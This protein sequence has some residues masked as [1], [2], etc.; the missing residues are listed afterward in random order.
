MFI[1]VQY[2]KYITALYFSSYLTENKTIRAL[3]SIYRHT[4]NT[5][6][7]ALHIPLNVIQK[8]K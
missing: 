7:I 3:N 1:V 5:L 2:V 4:V 6:F 8:F